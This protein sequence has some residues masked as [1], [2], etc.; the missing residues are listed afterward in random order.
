MLGVKQEE[1]VSYRQEHRQN[2]IHLNG[3]LAYFFHQQLLPPS[4]TAFRAGD[5]AKQQR[6]ISSPLPV[7]QDEWS[8]RHRVSEVPQNPEM[9][10]PF[11]CARKLW[12]IV[13][14]WDVLWQLLVL[15]A[16]QRSP[17]LFVKGSAAD[18]ECENENLNGSVLVNVFFQ[19]GLQAIVQTVKKLSVS[20]IFLLLLFS[21]VS[22]SAHPSSL[23]LWADTGVVI[24]QTEFWKTV[25]C[26]QQ[27]VGYVEESGDGLGVRASRREHLK[28]K[29]EQDNKTILC[30]Y[31]NIYRYA[32]SVKVLHIQYLHIYSVSAF[33]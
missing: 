7:N 16:D 26:A 24:Y 13:Q 28:N 8:G 22:L 4:Q 32:T 1:V 17:T 27:D 21:S 31:A 18:L 2:Y 6:I 25:G 30:S 9:W 20:S 10:I 23:C 11:L 33:S 19:W 5:L 15:E 12:P 14:M 29:D 3:G